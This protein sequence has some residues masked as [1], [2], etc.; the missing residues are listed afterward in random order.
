MNSTKP[1]FIFQIDIVDYQDEKEIIDSFKKLLKLTK[2]QEFID[3]VFWEDG[4]N[5]SV[6]VSPTISFI[7]SGC[8]S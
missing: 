4:E 1:N 7:I 2:D 8:N 5:V 3:S 6:Y